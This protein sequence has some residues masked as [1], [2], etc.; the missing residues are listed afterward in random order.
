VFLHFTEM[1]LF[2]GFALYLSALRINPLSASSGSTYPSSGRFRGSF[3]PKDLFSGSETS[4]SESGSDSGSDSGSTSG[5]ESGSKTSGSDSGST[6]GSESGSETSGSESGSA[7]NGA[8]SSSGSVSG[9]PFGIAQ[10]AT[11]VEVKITTYA[12]PDN[13]AGNLVGF[14]QGCYSDAIAHTTF[15]TRADEGDGT[16]T[17]PSTCAVSVGNTLFPQNSII[18]IGPPYYR[19]CRVEDDC[20]SCDIDNW[21]DLWIGPNGQETTTPMSAA[22]AIALCGTAPGSDCSCDDGTC[23]TTGGCESDLTS[24]DTPNIPAVANAN[25]ASGV[26]WV[27]RMFDWSTGVCANLS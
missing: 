1:Y 23:G 6:S 4:G 14:G 11:T 8:S 13:D 5:S 24:D 2:L 25:S 26:P 3:V 9:S 7:G 12:F 19:F 18:Y 21:I 17:N 15:R 22:Y 27:R 10:G 16:F 20:S